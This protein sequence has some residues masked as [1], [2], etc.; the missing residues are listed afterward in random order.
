LAAA[1]ILAA[2]S[3]TIW[4]PVRHCVITGTKRY[5]AADCEA[6]LGLPAERWN[7]FTC[8]RAVL[9]KRLR[10]TLP[11]LKSVEIRR[12][13]PGTLRLTVR[14]AVPAMIVRQDKL[15]WLLDEDLKLLEQRPDTS[16]PTEEP[17]IPENPAAPEESEPAPD[18]P[19]IP[20]AED[21]LGGL[22]LVTGSALVH[23]AAGH[24]AQFRNS[25]GAAVLPTLVRALR[26]SPLAGEVTGAAVGTLAEETDLLY[27]NRIRIHFGPSPAE[28]K[29]SESEVFAYKLALAAKALEDVDQKNPLQR[30]VLDLSTYGKAYFYPDWH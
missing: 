26:D 2:L 28:T 22:L 15:L 3:L 20:A 25:A 17:E 23:P 21:P 13:P 16:D 14:E 11:Y 9:D 5:S 12:S 1:G 19:E 27:Q 29:K 7:V 4:F 8:R 30:G 10:Q 18:N 24:T 6:A